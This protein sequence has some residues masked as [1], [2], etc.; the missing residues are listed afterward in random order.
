[1]IL[2]IPITTIHAERCFHRPTPLLLAPV[3]RQPYPGLFQQDTVLL[4]S[5][6]M[7]QQLLRRCG[8]VTLLTLLSAEMS[9]ALQSHRQLFQDT[10]TSGGYIQMILQQEC[11]VLLLEGTLHVQKLLHAFHP[12]IKIA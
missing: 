7:I 6:C 12:A 10:H 9:A 3:L 8:T 1:M 11:T 2:I 4:C 5:G